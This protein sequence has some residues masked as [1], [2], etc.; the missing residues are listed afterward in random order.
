MRARCQGNKDGRRQDVGEFPGGSHD[1]G[2]PCFL[3][4]NQHKEQAMRTEEYPTAAAVRAEESAADEM[5]NEVLVG[6][7]ADYVIKSR[8]YADGI[9]AALKALGT[10][11]ELDWQENQGLTGHVFLENRLEVIESAASKALSGDCSPAKLDELM[12]TIVEAVAEL[13]G[14]LEVEP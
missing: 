11:D 14:K 5:G 1:A 10:E 12:L 4:T 6:S 9:D 13:R 2:R 8:S 3:I 7:F